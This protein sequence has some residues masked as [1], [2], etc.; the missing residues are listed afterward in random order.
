MNDYLF[1]G[2]VIMT[3][4]VFVLFLAMVAFPT[5]RKKRGLP[6]HSAYDESQQMVNDLVN[7]YNY[8]SINPNLSNMGREIDSGT[9]KYKGEFWKPKI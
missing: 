7:L 3:V 8:H 6:K 2:I 9:E 5:Q 1:A 4:V